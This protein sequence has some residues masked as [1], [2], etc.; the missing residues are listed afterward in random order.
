LANKQN[1]DALYDLFSKLLD[2]KLVDIQ[3]NSPKT[4]DYISSDIE[5]DYIGMMHPS[6]QVVILIE[7]TLYVDGI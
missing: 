5:D 1:T 2:R 4:E 6:L 7:C 3:R